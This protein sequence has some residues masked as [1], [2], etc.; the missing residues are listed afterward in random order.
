MSIR[1]RVQKIISGFWQLNFWLKGLIFIGLVAGVIFLIGTIF[2]RK[3]NVLSGQIAFSP[4]GKFIAAATDKGVEIWSV[5]DRSLV[6]TFPDP[7]ANIVAWSP[8][9]QYIAANGAGGPVSVWQIKDATLRYKLLGHTA[10]VESLAFSPD[11][12]LLASGSE[13]NT[14]RLWRL[15]DGSLVSKLE[16]HKDWVKSLAF[17]PDGQLLASGSQN[18]PPSRLAY[19]LR[20]WRVSDGSIVRLFE[21]DPLLQDP[22]GQIATLAFS[23]DGQILATGGTDGLSLWNVKDGSLLRTIRVDDPVSTLAIS[24]DGKLLAVGF[25]PVFASGFEHPYTNINLYEMNSGLLA[26]KL[27][28]HSN[29]M[30]SLA[31]NPDGKLLASSSEDKTIRFWQL[32]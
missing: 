8:D 2:D 28:G 22:I 15:D 23:P 19:S 5:S 32:S 6:Q 11:S 21:R 24:P 7:A 16:G 29:I 9:G 10:E 1:N 17:S 27:E 30:Y 4:D 18:S 14:I 25:G 13:D 20:L 3:I 12:K 26:K 31:F